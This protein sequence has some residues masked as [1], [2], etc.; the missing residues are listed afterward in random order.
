M[1][2]VLKGKGHDTLDYNDEDGYLKIKLIKEY[3]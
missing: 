2:M 3:L 1:K